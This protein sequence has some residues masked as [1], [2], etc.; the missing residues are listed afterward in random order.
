[1][2]CKI[3]AV[4]SSFTALSKKESE[5]FM[6][7]AASRLSRKS[8]RLYWSLAGSIFIVL[9][10]ALSSQVPVAQAGTSPAEHSHISKPMYEKTLSGFNRKPMNLARFRGKKVYIKFWATWCPLCLAG[11]EDFAALSEQLS[12]SPD[13]A[14]ISIVSPGHYGEVSKKDFS[15][16]A[17]AQNLSFPIYFDESGALFKEFGIQILPTGVYLSQDGRVMKKTEGDES[18]EQIKTVLISAG[19]R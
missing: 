3:E 14:V 10:W 18:N 16:W 11:L 9:A 2:I 7:I 6:K 12:S 8:R 19:N 1:M 13:I 5:S 17:K 15:S 4:T